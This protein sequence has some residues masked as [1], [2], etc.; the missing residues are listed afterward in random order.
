MTL[1]LS[2]QYNKWKETTLKKSLDKF[3][4][5]KE[6]FETTAGIEVPRLALPSQPDS[7]SDD[8]SYADKLG[9]PGPCVSMQASPL[10]KT[11]INAIVIYSSTDKPG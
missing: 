5:R 8:S 3:K 11:Q 4:E 9:F 6:R 2:E 10:P 7:A 1:N